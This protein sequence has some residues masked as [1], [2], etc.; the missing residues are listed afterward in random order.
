MT[1]D[2][3]DVELEESS[4]PWSQTGEETSEVTGQVTSGLNVGGLVAVVAIVAAVIGSLTLLSNQGDESVSESASPTTLP[5]TST[6]NAT[7]NGGDAASTVPI[8]EPEPR[9]V[10]TPPTTLVPGQ[11]LLG[12]PTRLW[13]FY[14]GADPLQ[15]LNLD[16]GEF[17]E[18]GLQA[19]PVAATGEDLVVHQAQSGVS[20]WVLAANPAEQAL[21]WKRGPVALAPEPGQ[22]WLLDATGAREHPSG[23][24]VGGGRWQLFDLA[25]NRLIE[26]RPGDLYAQVEQQ[27]AAFSD[28]AADNP[29]DRHRPV[30]PDYSNRPDGLYRYGDDGYRKVSDGWAIAVDGPTILVRTCG[31]FTT[32]PCPLAWLDGETGEQ[33]VKRVPEGDVTSVALPR[34]GAVML[35]ADRS[36]V[37]S[38]VDVE[39]G[40]VE[41][42]DRYQQVALSPD[43]RWLAG[44]TADELI[45]EDL[46]EVQAPFR[47]RDLKRAGNDAGGGTLL[48][49]EQ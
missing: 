34:S 18:Y 23:E 39:S 16:N 15:R 44:L 22:A 33:L 49:V 4:R 46:M 20:G 3:L 31:D 29:F 47:Y 11:L 24:A 2:R 48:F 6:P 17:I 21:N 5:A 27:L 30:G 19:H 25:D 36:G 1:Q 37:S 26:Q 7:G 41:L 38:L 42:L 8:E 10:F 28:A 13:L 12:E 45:I 35:V 9:I 14:G 40:A 32:A 43:G